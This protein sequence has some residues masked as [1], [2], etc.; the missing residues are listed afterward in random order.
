MSKKNFHTFFDCGASKVR[1]GILNKDNENEM[2]YN[3]SEFFTDPANSE[4][5]I[6]KIITSF[7]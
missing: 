1:G 5:A 4:I 3:E 6:Q 7:E 2:F